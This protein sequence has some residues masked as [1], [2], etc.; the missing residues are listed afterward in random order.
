MSMQ[1]NTAMRAMVTAGDRQIDLVPL[2]GLLDDLAPIAKLQWVPGADRDDIKVGETA[3]TLGFNKLRRG[4]VT[5][6]GPKRIT[7][8]FTTPGTVANAA[9][10]GFDVTVYSSATP[11]MYVR[12]FRTGAAK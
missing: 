2:I 12:V 11:G 7:V 10:G 4:V 1:P 9:A 6:V 5:K 3:Y 8:A